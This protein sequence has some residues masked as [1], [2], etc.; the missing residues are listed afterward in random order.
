MIRKLFV[1]LAALALTLPLAVVPVAAHTSGGFTLDYTQYADGTE[2]HVVGSIQNHYSGRRSAIVVTA[3]WKVGTTTVATQNV[4]VPATNLAPHASW[5]FHLV[6]GD[7]TTGATL[8]VTASSSSSGVLPTGGLYVEGA[9][10]DIVGVDTIT[11]TVE[12]DGSAAANNVV[13]Y[14]VRA[15]GTVEL[16]AGASATI[17]SIG[18]GGS[19]PFTITLDRDIAGGEVVLLTARTTTGS[20][21]TSWNNYFG[22]LGTSVARTE[23]EYLAHAG[24]T[25]GCGN[26]NYCPSASV[27]REQM[28]IFLDRALGLTDVPLTTQF[29]DIGTR[30]AE[31]KQAISNLVAAGITNGCAADKFCPTQTTTRGQMSKFVAIGYE[32]PD[33]VADHFT[34]DTGNFSEPYNNQI[35][36]AGIYLGCGGGKFCHLSVMTRELMAQWLYNAETP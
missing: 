22:D 36:E 12:N 34:D 13:V 20:Y 11:G 5:P 6:E 17:T 4:T 27:T 15:N 26:A 2:T 9:L 31:A 33:A 35:Q 10:N 7:D 8:T 3:T 32:L 14:A 30:S 24:I 28:A 29:T 25:I 1:A 21:Y 19:A 23:I 16:D 18:A